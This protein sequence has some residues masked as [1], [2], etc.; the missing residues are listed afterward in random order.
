VT[1]MKD[2]G[3]VIVTWNSAGTLEECLGSISA[4]VAGLA[5]QTIVIDNA[6]KD[7]SAGIASRY[8]NTQVVRNTANRGFAAASNQGI[9]E[10]LEESRFILLLNPD[11]VVQPD[12]LRVLAQFLEIDQTAGAC[13][14]RL[15][16][17]DGT[18]QP[19]AFGQDPTL[20][21]L[22][23][24]AFFRLVYNRS[25]HD[26]DYREIRPVDWISGACL[27]ARHSAIKQAGL[28]D[29]SMFIYFED[30]DWCLRMRR[31]GW[32]IMCDPEAIVVHT[33]GQSLGQNPA[34]QREYYRSLCRFYAKHYGL[35]NRMALRALLPIYR[36]LAN[37]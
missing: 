36:R 18:P 6:S 27:L 4:G 32:R 22:L 3:I 13:G 11:T 16:L 15:L 30:N 26:W 35:M 29:G 10:L 37:R 9:M 20:G 7:D 24:R 28:L 12:S 21:Y 5:Y 19:F 33:G 25:L 8:P 31:A 1:A 34:A 14:P 17:P 23:K 2:I